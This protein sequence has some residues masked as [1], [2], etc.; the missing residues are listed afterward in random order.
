MTKKKDKY[1]SIGGQALMEGVMM[2]G[3]DTSAIAVRKPDGEIVTKVE[4]IKGISKSK[5]MKIPFLRGSIILVSSMIV[6]TK[7]LM[8]S[9][10]FF[11]VEEEETEKA[12]ANQEENSSEKAKESEYEPTGF[13]KFIYDK[14]GDSADTVL[15]WISMIIAMFLAIF[16]FI[17]IPTTLIGFLRPII[18]SQ[19][20]LS[21]L[22]GMTKLTVFILYIYLI[23]KNREIQRVFQY[24]GAEH[25][26]IHCFEAGIELTPENAQKFTT[27]HPRCGTSFMFVVITVSILVF[28]FVSWNSL[29][30]RMLLKLIMLPLIAGLSYEIIK[31]TSRHDNAFSKAISFPGMMMQKLTTKEPDLNQLAVAIVAMN[32][33]LEREGSDK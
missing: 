10:E 14:L 28:T 29:I 25:K 22:E 33:V 8:W 2:R 20:L 11:E 27:L 9:A 18:E 4:E 21:F 30:F 26:T 17:I 23:S 31:W 19:I 6:G 5:L 1:T 3:K 13:E 7:A 15:I 12:S 16:L 32:M 24:H